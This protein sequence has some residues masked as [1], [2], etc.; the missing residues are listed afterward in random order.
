MGPDL[1]D[2]LVEDH[3]R[4]ERLFT[5]IAGSA[6]PTERGGDLVAATIAELSRHIVVEEEYL[7]PLINA[8]PTGGPA[9]AADALRESQHAEVLMKR[10][11]RAVH[12][13]DADRVVADLCWVVEGHVRTTEGELFPVLRRECPP[14]DL[15][16]LAGVVEMARRTAPTRAHPGAPSTPPWNQILAPG[17]GLIDK[18]RDALAGRP[19]RREDV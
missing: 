10:L 14:D 17:L 13:G 19:T 3:R 16:H 18:L 7:Y 5:E 11:E 1:V 12:D 15:Q 8:I 2:V 4:I 9:M 6:D